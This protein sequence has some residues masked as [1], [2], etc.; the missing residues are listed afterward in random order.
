[1]GSRDA[2]VYALNVTT[3]ELVW[4][5]TTGGPILS[6]PAVD[7]GLVYVGSYDGKL[8]VFNATGG[9][10]IWNSTVI[11]PG[12]I[13]I[14]SRIYSSASI[15]YD[16]VFVASLDN[17]IHALDQFNGEWI[18]NY[19]TGGSI[20]SSPAIG[21][22]V[23]VI[24]S[25]DGKV[26]AIG[27]PERP[28]YIGFW[29]KPN[30]T[31]IES[32]QGKVS[33]IFDTI[34]VIAANLSSQALRLLSNESQIEYIEDIPVETV[35]G[36]NVPWNIN[37]VGATTA[38][39]FSR[40]T[41]V[42]IAVLDTGIDY[43]HPDLSENYKGG[44]DFIN[45]DPD[46][47]DDHEEKI[48]FPPWIP[49]WPS[50]IVISHSHGTH[51]SGIIGARDNEIGVVGVAPE[52]ELYAVKVLNEKGY[53]MIS[54]VGEGIEWAIKNNMDVIH[55][56]L[57]ADYP[58]DTR[59]RL[60]DEAYT[61]GILIVAAA[62]NNWGGHV[63]YPAAFPSVIA[64]ASYDV[65]L[66][67]SHFTSVGPEVELSAPGATL[68]TSLGY[69]GILSTIRVAIDSEDPYGRMCGTSMAAPH[70]T[71]AAALVWSKAPWLTN[72]DVRRILARTAMDWGPS[73]RDEIYGYG[74]LSA[75]DAV[76]HESVP[77]A[78]TSGPQNALL[79]P[80]EFVDIKHHENHNRTYFNEFFSK[81]DHYWRTVSY[82]K[83]YYITPTILDWQ[84][85]NSE[86]Q[87][88]GKNE[89]YA[90]LVH[91]SLSKAESLSYSPA[92]YDQI[93]I[94]YAGYSEQISENASDIK[95][96]AYN[97]QEPQITWKD[98]TIKIAWVSE[99]DP[100][101]V[102]ALEIGVM[103]GNPYL[104][105][106]DS[107]Q[108]VS[109]N[110][111]F[112]DNFVGPWSLMGFGYRLP[113]PY[114]TMP[115]Y[116]SIWTLKK[117]G[118]MP[119]EG[120]GLI[121]SPGEMTFKVWYREEHPPEGWLNLSLYEPQVWAVKVML[122]F[123]HYYIIEFVRKIRYDQYLPQEGVLIT[124]VDE[125]NFY[126]YNPGTQIEDPPLRVM[127][128]IDSTPSLHDALFDVGDQFVKVEENINIT[129]LGRHV[130]QDGEYY[131]IKVE[132]LYGLRHDLRIE[133]RAVSY[134]ISIDSPQDGYTDPVQIH[135]LFGKDGK[136]ERP[137][138]G[139]KNIIYA[140]IWNIGGP[141][142]NPTEPITVTFLYSE[143][144]V[145]DWHLFIPERKTEWH[146]IGKATIP[147]KRFPGY[148][149]YEIVN[150]T[151]ITPKLEYHPCVKVKIEK[152]P[153][154]RLHTNNEATEN[155]YPIEATSSSPFYP[156]VYKVYVVNPYSNSNATIEWNLRELEGKLS[157]EWLSQ[158]VILTW[159][160]G[161]RITKP[162][163][164]I[165]A[166][167]SMGIQI[168]V[169]TLTTTFGEKFQILFT[170]YVNSVTETPA[171]MIVVPS[172]AV[173]MEITAKRPS[174]ISAVIPKTTYCPSE[175]VEI[176][177]EIQPSAYVDPP[178]G[179][180]LLRLED[181]YTIVE[182]AYALPNG[183]FSFSI[184]LDIGTYNGTT[185]WL[186]TD[187]LAS[188][189]SPVFQFKVVYPDVAVIDL[190]ASES[191]VNVTVENQG[192]TTITF[193]LSTYYERITDPLIGT[194]NVTLQSGASTTVT[195]TW[196]PPAYGRY[197]ILANVSQVPGEV[198]L[199]DNSLTIIYAW[200]GSG[201]NL[202]SE[203]IDGYRAVTFIFAL[204]ASIIVLT[205]RKNREM[206][207]LDMPTFFI[208]QNI[209]NDLL[210]HP[211][212]I[213]QEQ[214]RQKPI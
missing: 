53:S 209:H 134:D 105:N 10:F 4:N 57:G 160:N 109:L 135:E 193:T 127:D 196:E 61:R 117:F 29:E 169:T 52:A 181:N 149:E 79:I 176:S 78:P 139:H 191:Y 85:L 162:S 170:A 89:N 121:S 199:E 26:Y 186:G 146:E 150:I 145:I 92:S 24:G 123:N 148:H 28:Y 21:N 40:G 12:W 49:F 156:M 107:S 140:R 110:S 74:L 119:E 50:W 54:S 96:G 31:L 35:L 205:L 17:N 22:G 98:K 136:D 165:R 125:N 180:N 37:S 55:M 163:F 161:T 5:Y 20:Y 87:Y 83:M 152:Y 18:W 77:A 13:D 192:C 194:Q 7:R 210:N 25:S 154:E 73:G 104:F 94:V 207:L 62:G 16:T 9:T 46:P 106:Y 126:T 33:Y 44:W 76:M 91:D 2:K 71:G 6:S 66:H 59:R 198:D 90:A 203:S 197:K 211:A 187:C 164:Q 184:Q 58:S 179:I 157:H 32:H 175:T 128:H 39:S 133:G 130:H 189:I 142:H 202:G 27:N 14:G 84:T 195:F 82:N 101:G 64:V 100:L 173:V 86:K 103:L 178:V 43:N 185:S 36:Q 67:R 143:R 11:P 131:R 190:T 41:G 137:W 113:Y 172:G 102:W 158:H 42:K 213:W 167:S 80:V 15:A 95:H 51:V 214:M 204:F 118:W 168:N 68:L 88:Y 1:V 129:I 38:H 182:T 155:V 65:L 183:S 111:E 108:W 69:V 47:Y 141:L 34:P 115:S 120:V 112:D 70:V 166:N 45:N 144:G 159:E 75:D 23:V 206:S 72:D 124:Y 171:A 97:I 93:L 116:P 212:N 153:G 19:T 99:Y 201:G 174:T 138:I 200:Y 177:G 3:G 147:P 8:Y 81:V 208:K 132:N 30:A 122:D 60:C 63:D 48:Y 114:G 188:A 56:S 151:W